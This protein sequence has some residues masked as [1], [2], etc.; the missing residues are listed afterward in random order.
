M[1]LAVRNLVFTVVVPG[2]VGVYVPLFIVGS[3]G[4]LP[5]PAVWPG[6]ALVVIGV[7]LYGWCLGL[8]ALVGRGT[9]GPWD[10]PRRLVATGPYRWVRNP[11]YIAVLA[12]VL[13]EATLFR[14]L[15]LLIYAGAVAIAF[16]VFVIAYEE[17]TLRDSFGE[18]Y[19]EYTGQVSRWLP[20]PPRRS[21][22]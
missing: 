16:H 13:G 12:V 21:N 6:F 10:S 5:A 14:S 20:R 8:F 11:I 17:P 22:R 18:S 9:P 4:T 7:V 19:R 3:G 15:P 2:T 1:S